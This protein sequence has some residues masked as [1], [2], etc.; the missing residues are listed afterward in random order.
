MIKFNINNIINKELYLHFLN[1]EKKT[2]NITKIKLFF[3][4]VLAGFFI[5]MASILLIVITYIIYSK[6]LPLIM[7]YKFMGTC[8]LA[9]LS[10]FI[11]YI[12]SSSSEKIKESKVSPEPY[13]L[14]N[15][16]DFINQYR[17]FISDEVKN[18]IKEVKKQDR[19]LLTEEIKSIKNIIRHR[20][21]EINKSPQYFNELSSLISQHDDTREFISELKNKM[22]AK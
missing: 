2:E 22:A 6:D 3:L 12:S 7:S 17:Y 9:C 1:E 5:L 15:F 14:C 20:A 19:D 18:Y 8:V 4:E 21:D 13:D 10:I 16:A 11:F